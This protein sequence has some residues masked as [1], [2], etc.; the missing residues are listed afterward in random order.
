M[1]ERSAQGNAAP[2][3]IIQGP[4]TQLNWPAQMFLDQERG[5]LY[6][7]NDGADS[8]LV[9]PARADGDVA[10]IR[11]IQGPSTR[12]SNPTGI[13]LDTKNDEVVVS[14]MGNHSASTFSRTANGNVSPLRTIRAAPL[15]KTALAIGNPGGVAYDSKR[16]QLLVPN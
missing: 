10:P 1:Y 6:V 8:V 9:F 4:K 14:S 5:E 12:L 11:V 15:G 7:A 3:R 2:L 16:D 13:W